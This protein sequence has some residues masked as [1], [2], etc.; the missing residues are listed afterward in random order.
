MSEL[1]SETYNRPLGL[2]VR[3]K[4][5]DLN[6][7]EHS[8]DLPA[9]TRAERV[10]KER[11]GS[12]IGVI[13]EWPSLNSPSEAG[14]KFDS[15][16]VWSEICM[17]SGKRIARADFENHIEECP[18]CANRV[19]LQLDFVNTLEVAVYQRQAEPDS[20]KVHGAMLVSA[21]ALNF[22]ICGEIESA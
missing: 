8:S 2:T 12:I 6:H 13:G 11:A 16:N 4:L 22:A 21:P 3:V 14:R 7:C 18:V 20:P 15:T 17:L 10:A 5:L 1:T 9:Q 19:D